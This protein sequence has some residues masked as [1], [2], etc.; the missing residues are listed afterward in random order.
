[1]TFR[2]VDERGRAVASGKD[3]AELQRRLGTKVRES[4]AKASAATPKNAIERGGLTTWDFVELPR[5]IDTKQGDNTIR[6][7]PT[8]IDDGT[9]VSIR[10][11]STAEEQA[12]TLPGGVRRL[13][14]L[15]TA[16]PVAYVQQHLTGGEKLSL[17]TSPYRS[18]QAL[19]DDCLAAAVDDVL[20]RV[21]PD[22]L[23]FMKAEFD[24]IRDRVSGV[25]M[26]SM[27]ETVGLVARIL[28]AS[29]AADKALKGSTSMAL[30]AAL[31]D[32]REQLNGLV[33]PG[34][35]SATGLAQLR[36]VPRYLGGISA[37]IEKLLDNPNRDRVW[38]N[39]VQSAT[40]KFTDAGG[41]IPLP[42]DAA[43]HLVRARWMIE[44]LR[45]SLFA[46]ELRAAESVSL[47]RIQKVLAS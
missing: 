40:A 25:V 4:V 15:A 17:A 47:Q 23:V 3:L 10:M 5:F 1:M 7:Y 29:R 31:T 22:G 44:E 9:S 43:P 19:F 33:F 42:A 13:L 35:V 26:D 20:Y 34:F 38:M 32:A 37:R 36:H 21:R 11:M 6:G 2:V 16:S 24:S 8:L 14:L 46:Q 41:R 27:F 28:T 18:T 39:E 30:L 45:I 12:R